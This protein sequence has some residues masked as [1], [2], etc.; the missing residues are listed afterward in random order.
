M[1]AAPCSPISS[2]TFANP[3]AVPCPPVMEI[4]PEAIPIKGSTPIRRVIPI[5]IKFCIVIMATSRPSMMNKSL[6][7]FL[8]TLRLLWKPTLVKNAS[9]N[10][11]FNVP[12]NDTSISNQLY[13]IRVINE[14]MI[15]PLTGEGTQNF[16]RKATFRVKVMPTMRA[17]A[18]M[19]AVCIISSSIVVI[20]PTKIQRIMRN[21][22]NSQISYVFL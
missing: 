7:P 2:R 8:M 5:G 18:P 13:R 6:P 21:V 17:R 16:W 3:P 12:S 22:K 15:P 1:V 19:P 20:S 11:S 14:K 9:M 10:T 4:L